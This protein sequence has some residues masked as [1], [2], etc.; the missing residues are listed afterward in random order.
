MRDTWAAP[1]RGWP[2]FAS[3]GSIVKDSIF[4]RAAGLL[5]DRGRCTG[6]FEDVNGCLD[7]IGALRLA[8]HGNSDFHPETTAGQCEEAGN[9]LTGLIS[10]PLDRFSDDPAITDVDVL[11]LLERAD[12]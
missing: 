6:E 12:G 11:A 2:D 5:K 4:S 8:C 7:L 3:D 10:R 1:T 9:L